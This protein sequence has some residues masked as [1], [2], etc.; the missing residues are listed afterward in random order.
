MPHAEFYPVSEYFYTISYDILHI[1]KVN[2]YESS[3]S[4]F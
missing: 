4:Q 1:S 2:N 3:G